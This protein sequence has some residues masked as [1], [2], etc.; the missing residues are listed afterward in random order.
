MEKMMTM[1]YA[2]ETIDLV[3]RHLTSARRE[4]GGFRGGFGGGGRVDSFGGM[5]SALRGMKG[6]LSISLTPKRV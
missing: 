1:E 6:P 4:R 3:K 5:L 2:I